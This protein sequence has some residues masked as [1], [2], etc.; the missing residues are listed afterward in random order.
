MA[1]DYVTNFQAQPGRPTVYLTNKAAGTKYYIAVDGYNGASGTVLLN[2]G[3][4]YLPQVKTPPA[5]QYVVL[6]SNAT[7]NVT[8]SGATN[9]YYQWQFNGANIAK[10]TNTLYTV[11]NTITANAGSY[12]VIVSNIVGV[13]TSTPP[14]TLT[15][16]TNPVITVPPTNQTVFL[17]QKAG[18]AVTVVGV[19]STTNRLRYQW[20]FT[21]NSVP[22]ARL[23][24]ATNSTLAF[25]AA[26]YANN[27]SYYVTITNTYGGATS[28]VVTLTVVDTNRPTVVFTSPPNNFSTNAG[29][30][31]VTGTASD[32][33]LAVTNVQVEVNQSGF[34]TANGTT[35]WTNTVT[36][37]PG[38]NLISAYSVNQ[39]GT[40]SL[41]QT[42]HLVYQVHSPLTVQTNL[43]GAGRVTSTSGATNGASLII[44]QNYTITAT[45]GSNYLFTNWTSGTSPGPLTN[46]PGGTNLTFMMFSNMVLQANF[47]T[48]PFLAL[49]GSYNGLFYP[50]N[51]VTEASSGYINVAV[52]SNSAGTYTATLMLD[53]GTYKY[54]GAF[55]L[56]GI[57]Q[58]NLLRAGTN[59]VLVTLNLDFDPADAFMGGSVSNAA[60]GWNSVIQADRAVFNT[61]ANP[62][63]NYAGHFTLLLPPDAATA[64]ATSPDGYG[65]AAITNTPGGNSTLGGF[66]ADGTFF[67]WSAPISQNGAVPLYQS[68]YSGKGSLLGWIYFTNEPPKIVQTNSSVSW[69]KPSV[70]KTMYPSGFTNLLTNVFG[71]FYTNTAGQPVLSLTNATLDLDNGNLHGGGLTFTNL[72]LSHNTLTNLAGKTNYGPTNYL[73]LAANPTNGEV[74]VTFQATGSKTNTV[75][76]G[77][78]LQNQTNA[79]GYFPGTNQTGSFIL[80]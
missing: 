9:L 47:V 6:G 56:N 17:G 45:H 69:I 65:W 55:G 77:A 1:G 3:L 71:S 68:L 12:S 23:A 70:S 10:A 21:S 74:K 29:T 11:T 22:A 31:T 16:A 41:T 4:G 75:G 79:A 2:A 51:G 18:F 14:A 78:V 7:F 27:G 50:T 37:V 72:N 28:A 60:T 33:Y 44:G 36:L 66:L 15:L 35:K 13:V 26:P 67:S 32:K 73:L 54:S 24:G 52:V 49:A 30:V 5:S 19:N 64:P 34:Q 57:A 38:T 25:P 40:N 8:A 61:N 39:A 42:L 53:G 63:T 46:Y 20:F 48:N 62:A 43:P 59:P 76:T 58:T 80:H